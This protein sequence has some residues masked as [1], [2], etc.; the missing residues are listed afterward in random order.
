MNSKRSLLAE[1]AFA[2]VVALAEMEAQLRETT[3]SAPDDCVLEA[4]SVKVGDVL[5]GD[6]DRLRDG[7]SVAV[8]FPNVP[9][10]PK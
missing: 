4:L 5:L 9:A 3:I 7:G 1:M 2:A 6:T 8:S 10:P